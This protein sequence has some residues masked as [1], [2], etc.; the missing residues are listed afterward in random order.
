[1]RRDTAPGGEIRPG[2]SRGETVTESPQ[3]IR[4]AT[5]TL[6]IAVNTRIR[7]GPTLGDLES[8]RAG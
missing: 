1:M 6:G 4:F 7:G 3:P 8:D 2:V 5:S